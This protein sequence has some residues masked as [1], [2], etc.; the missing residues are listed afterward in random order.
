MQIK[1]PT[2]L[3]LAT[4]G[5]IAGLSHA[6]GGGAY[7]A[8]QLSVDELMLSISQAVA[9]GIHIE[10]EQL[11]QVD[12]KDMDFGVW[13][14]LA[15][16]LAWHV[17]R[18]EVAGVVVTHG[19]DTLE[20]TAFFLR[21]VLRL[22]KPVL[23]TAAMRPADSPEADGPLNLMQAIELAAQGGWAGVAV[24]LHGALHDAL[25]VRKVHPRAIDAFDSG[26][27]GPLAVHNGQR[28]VW[29]HRPQES[30]AHGLWSA[31][32]PSHTWPWV[33]LVHSHA[34]ARAETVDAL[35]S[36]GVRGLVVVATGNGT[37]HQALEGALEKAASC[38]VWVWRAS[39]CV[40]YGLETQ[41]SGRWHASEFIPCK[42][43][44]ALMLNLMAQDR[45]GR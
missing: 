1:T 11:A 38:G 21:S 33:E 45:Q 19:T 34:G 3:I 44:I 4:G 12:S 27:A 28:W 16:R 15:Q 36:A 6:G 30:S 29:R 9:N 14:R 42:A 17:S 24:A 39:R 10:T 22:H 2:V 23:L 31:L 43:R 25:W 7:K 40:P 32:P 5:T 41:G 8:A 13:R 37:V 18:P 26:E 35:V 20:E